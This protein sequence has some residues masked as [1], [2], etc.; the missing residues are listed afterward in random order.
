M[1]IEI[2]SDDLATSDWLMEFMQTWIL[3]LNNDLF[4]IAVFLIIIS[5]TGSTLVQSF[6]S[7]SEPQIFNSKILP[8]STK[9]EG[10]PIIPIT[11]LL[12]VLPLVSL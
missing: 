7:T 10:N 4:T 6:G 11:I 1:I 2:T 5:F 8:K 3:N 12:S 9:K